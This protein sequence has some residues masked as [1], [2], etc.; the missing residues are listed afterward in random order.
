MI[1]RTLRCDGNRKGMAHGVWEGGGDGGGIVVAD[2][3]GYLDTS[4]ISNKVSLTLHR[5][6]LPVNRCTEYAPTC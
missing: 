2:F 3:I 6:P 4:G 5:D 1:S